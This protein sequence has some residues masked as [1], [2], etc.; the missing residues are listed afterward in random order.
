MLFTCVL[1]SP[2]AASHRAAPLAA[3]QAAHQ[4]ASLA[5]T[6]AAPQVAY[7]AVTQLDPQAAS[8]AA[9][10]K[11]MFPVFKYSTT[12]SGGFGHAGNTESACS[13]ANS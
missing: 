6:Q 7:Q 4:A 1:K 5:V 11:L 9:P 3:P 10:L 2:L 12:T 8:L 13:L